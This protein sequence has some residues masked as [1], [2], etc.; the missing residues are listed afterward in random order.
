MALAV[1]TRAPSSSEAPVP[2]ESVAPSETP[3]PELLPTGSQ[4]I[5]APLAGAFQAVVED[6]E[7]AFPYAFAVFRGGRSFRLYASNQPR[8][9]VWAAGGGVGPVFLGEIQ[10]SIDL[11]PVVQPDGTDWQARGFSWVG[12]R[13]SGFQAGN[14]GRLNWNAE[15]EIDE[16]RCAPRVVLRTS[17]EEARASV[18][19][20]AMIPCCPV[21]RESRP[22]SMSIR[23]GEEDYPL[24]VAVRT[25]DGE[26]SQLRISR[27]VDQCTGD[28]THEDVYFTVYLTEDEVTYSVGV[29]GL[30][31][32]D[33]LHRFLDP[34]TPAPL[35]I[36]VSPQRLSIQGQLDLEETTSQERIPMEIEGSVPL[37]ECPR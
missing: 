19:L 28:V 35:D 14:L 1:A 26:G 30:V 17:E 8:D 10:L 29:G 33:D 31:V 7:I 25:F 22:P 34:A 23:L 20:S 5:P 6:R 4:D 24:A 13:R 12:D 16:S 15:V 2:A 21:H 3:T 37:L 9:C 18:D 27:D 11:A 32:A 36:R